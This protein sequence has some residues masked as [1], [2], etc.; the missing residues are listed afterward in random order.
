[1]EV[2]AT[3]IKKSENHSHFKRE[4][5]VLIEV[6]E[7]GDE[8]GIFSFKQRFPDF[9]RLSE[10][11]VKYMKRYVRMFPNLVEIVLNTPETALIKESE[12]QLT[13]F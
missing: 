5:N 11:G 8:R 12:T 13:L 4:D 1:M 3:K 9:K 6:L 10:E 2:L 7:S